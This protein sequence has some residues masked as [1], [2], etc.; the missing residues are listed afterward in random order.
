VP[1]AQGTT[2][3]VLH[4]SSRDEYT[5][6]DR[7]GGVY[8]LVRPLG[9][10][11]TAWVFEARDVRRGNSVA[12]KIIRPMLL[13]DSD[14]EIDVGATEHISARLAVE[15]RAVAAIGHPGI[16]R[17]IEAGHT[18]YGHPYL[19]MEL[20]EGELLTEL[21][22]LWGRI[23]ERAAVQLLLPVASALA[24]AHA[25]GVVHRD[26]KPDNIFVVPLS[27]NGRRLPKLL[28]FGLARFLDETSTNRLTQAGAL[29]GSPGYMAPE[30]ARGEL[31]IDGRADIWALSVVLYELV[32]GRCPFLETTL[33]RTMMAV[34]DG[35]PEPTTA[36]G[37]DPALWAILQAGLAKRREDRW[38]SMEE[39]GGA[40][41]AW[42]WDRGAV[43]DVSGASIAERV[44]A[45]SIARTNVPRDSIPDD[46]RILVPHLPMPGR[47]A[48]GVFPIAPPPPSAPAA[49]PTERRPAPRRPLPRAAA[50]FAAL[51]L[52]AAVAGILWAALAAR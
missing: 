29:L 31:D 52:L 13:E 26:V 48:S 18:E 5:D 37:G 44:T 33:T 46:I 17:V 45:R 43:I 42:A 32:T 8:E 14:G 1:P 3:L 34:I 22:R 49:P 10:G 25:A 7:V 30:Q 2:T 50:V 12:L 47:P 28:D 6:G 24:A 11:A 41:A 23:P 39:F 40:L 21:I 51:I 27:G 35:Q 36:S 20:L 9:R 16:V 15:A 19:A 38:Q 4:S